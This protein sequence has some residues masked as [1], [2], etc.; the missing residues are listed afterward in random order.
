MAARRSIPGPDFVEVVQ[1]NDIRSGP[2]E[3][4]RDRADLAAADEIAR[5]AA[6]GN[7][8]D[9]IKKAS[10]SARM[11]CVRFRTWIDR[12]RKPIPGCQQFPV[13]NFKKLTWWPLTSSG[14]ER[15]HVKPCRG[16]FA[17]HV[18]SD[19]SAPV[20]FS[21]GMRGQS[22]CLDR[23]PRPRSQASTYRR[24]TLGNPDREQDLCVSAEQPRAKR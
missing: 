24:A 14:F 3:A 1:E 13:T 23:R 20:A 18:E 2:R 9:A 17:F 16:R 22:G 19:P 7:N 10:I 5:V 8:G 15:S 6:D 21:T 12:Q 4:G 11:C